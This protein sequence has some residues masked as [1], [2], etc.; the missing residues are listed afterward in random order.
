[1]AAKR[2]YISFDFDHDDDLKILLVGQAKNEDSPFEIVDRSIKEAITGDWKKSA[3]QRIKGAEVVAVICGHHTNTATGVAAEVEI[4]QE[5]EVPYFL[6]S[7]RA[8]GTN[9][10]P[11]TAKISD[12]I[13]DWS[14]P[15]LKR[16]VAGNR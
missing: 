2:V 5:E 7:G 10:K 14:W 3:R 13:Y 15:N 4:A 12:K 9:K 11:T 16:L 1:M 6:L 8:A